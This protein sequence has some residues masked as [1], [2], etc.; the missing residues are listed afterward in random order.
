MAK[1]RAPVVAFN[2][3]MFGS[4]A[5]GESVRQINAAQTDEARRRG[6]TRR[7]VEAI[8]ERRRLEREMEGDW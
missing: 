1:R 2:R 3:A 4:R 7:R 5:P 8:A 6:E